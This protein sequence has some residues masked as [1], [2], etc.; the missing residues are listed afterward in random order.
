MQGKQ[1]TSCLQPLRYTNT[2]F[3]PHIL[4]IAVDPILSTGSAKHCLDVTFVWLDCERGVILSRLSF[5]H[6]DVSEV[7]L[8][9]IPDTITAT[10]FNVGSITFV[11][12]LAHAT[13]LIPMDAKDLDASGFL[14]D[15]IRQSDEV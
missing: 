15:G 14:Q 8:A 1:N 6:D 7:S 11:A 9:I 5:S 2:S 4:H 12:R 3:F 10:S 13:C